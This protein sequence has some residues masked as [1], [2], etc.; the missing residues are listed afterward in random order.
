MAYVLDDFQLEAIC[1]RSGD[2]CGLHCASCQAFAANQRYH[3]CD[4]G[5]DDDDE[6]ED[7]DGGNDGFGTHW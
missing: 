4:S 1:E 6:D 3:N 2:M 5:Q 7:D